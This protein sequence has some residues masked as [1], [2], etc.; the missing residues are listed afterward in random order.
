MRNPQRPLPATRSCL[1]HSASSLQ[2][3]LGPRSAAASAP[4]RARARRRGGR[5]S[6]S[7]TSSA[8]RR[9]ARRG[10]STALGAARWTARR[11][12]RPRRGRGAGDRTRPCS[13]TTGAAPTIG[14]SWGRSSTRTYSPGARR[15]RPGGVASGIGGMHSVCRRHLAPRP[16]RDRGNEASFFSEGMPTI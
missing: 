14:G 5:T 11:S 4:W 10:T 7:P 15:P 2:R 8:A 16:G 1:A 9:A 3:Q 13:G 12:G 6:I